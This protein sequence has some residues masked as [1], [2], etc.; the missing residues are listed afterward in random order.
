[1]HAVELFAKVRL[2]V[3]RDD[4]L[5][6]QNASFEDVPGGTSMPYGMVICADCGSD[7]NP[8]NLSVQLSM[9][10]LFIDLDVDF[11]VL[12]ITAADVSHMNEVEGEAHQQWLLPPS[13]LPSSLLKTM[14]TVR[15]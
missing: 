9:V 4:E 7:R 13:L 14:M 12:E 2:L 10:F 1:M 11:L 15:Q 5:G 8:K 3:A 6:K